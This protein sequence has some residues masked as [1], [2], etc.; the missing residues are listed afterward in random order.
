MRLIESLDSQMEPIHR[1]LQNLVSCLRETSFSTT[2]RKKKHSKYCNTYMT[3]N[4]S[5]K[6]CNANE[7]KYLSIL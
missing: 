1:H 4:E 5:P 3:V 7:L 2:Q 6:T